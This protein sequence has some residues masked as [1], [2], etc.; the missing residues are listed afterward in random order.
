MQK[1]RLTIGL[2]TILLSFCF[3]LGCS[4]PPKEDSQASLKRRATEYWDAKVFGDWEKVY[5]YED[6]SFRKE[7]SFGKYVEYF[8]GAGVRWLGAK[9]E[10]VDIKASTGVVKTIVRF[11]SIFSAPVSNEGRKRLI[12]DTWHFVDGDWYHFLIDKQQA[13]KGKAENK[14]NGAAQKESR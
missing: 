13:A 8:S 4:G 10:S 7:V 11:Q 12:Q 14:T 2:T 5:Q 1:S 3:V 9:V 6:P